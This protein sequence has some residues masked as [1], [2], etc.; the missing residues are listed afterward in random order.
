MA[1]G[2]LDIVANASFC[3]LS[4]KSLLTLAHTRLLFLS[5]FYYFTSSLPSHIET[6][7]VIVIFYR[8]CRSGDSSIGMTNPTTSATTRLFVYFLPLLL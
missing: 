3:F 1:C 5:L 7:A 4:E 6:L 2:T 8:S